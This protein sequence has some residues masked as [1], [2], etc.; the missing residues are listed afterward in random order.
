MSLGST[1]VL[2]VEEARGVPASRYMPVLAGHEV[3]ESVRFDVGLRSRP[4][5]HRTDCS[6]V[7]SEASDEHEERSPRPRRVVLRQLDPR[8][9]VSNRT[10]VPVDGDG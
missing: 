4:Q 5:L 8:G 6:A 7:T 2:S 9:D 3:G 10:S 1:P